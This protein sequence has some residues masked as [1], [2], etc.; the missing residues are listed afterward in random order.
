MTS[1]YTDDG[2]GYVAV[3]SEASTVTVQ[4][5]M[6]R[7]QRVKEAPYIVEIACTLDGFQGSS[8]TC[9]AGTA[10]CKHKAC[11][12]W[13]LLKRTHELERST[14]DP[15]EPCYWKKPKYSSEILKDV[16]KHIFVK[17]F[18]T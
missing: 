7:H 9:R 1:K 3:K 6:T 8:C 15:E 13:W 17:V 5:Q 11:L 14:T 10:R 12:A 16:R 2:I 18:L 4:A